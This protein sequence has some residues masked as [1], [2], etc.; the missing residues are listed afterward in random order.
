[1]YIR[2][3]LADIKKDQAAPQGLHASSLHKMNNAIFNLPEGDVVDEALADTLFQSAENIRRDYILKRYDDPDNNFYYDYLAMLGTMQNQHFFTVEQTEKMLDWMREVISVS[4]PDAVADVIARMNGSMVPR[5]VVDLELEVARLNLEL[6]KFRELESAVA[7]L[8]NFVSTGTAATAAGTSAASSSSWWQ[9]PSMNV[10]AD[11][12][13]K[14]VAEPSRVAAEKAT[15]DLHGA[16]KEP[17]KGKGKSSIKGNDKEEPE[18]P[19]PPKLKVKGKSKGKL[20]EVPEEE[21]E[22]DANDNRSDVNFKLKLSSSFEKMFKGW[23]NEKDDNGSSS[24]KGGRSK[25]KDGKLCAVGPPTPRTAAVNPPAL[26]GKGDGNSSKCGETDAW[27]AVASSAMATKWR[28][29]SWERDF[30][31]HNRKDHV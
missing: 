2:E 28:P 19:K 11:A 7:V 1:M 29:H 5:D 24:G 16:H 18:T 8:T 21:E 4:S 3:V 9:A 25:V 10:T 17:R 12:K 15:N 26:R 30:G 27:A 13:P 20:D 6:G 14:E 31:R 23:E 22:A